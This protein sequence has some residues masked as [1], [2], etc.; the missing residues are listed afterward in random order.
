M[1]SDMWLTGLLV[2]ADKTGND[3]LVKYFCIL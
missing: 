2:I 3:Y 1:I